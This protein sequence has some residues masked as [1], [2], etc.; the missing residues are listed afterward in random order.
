M[1]KNWLIKNNSKKLIL[2]FNG[3]GMD[4]SAVSHLENSGYDIIEFH[5]YRIIDFEEREYS[6]YKE[7]YL[8]AW[9]LG[10][11]AASCA[12]E[13]SSLP[14]TKSIAINGTQNP[15]HP[16]EGIHPAIFEGTI[17]G[18]NEKNK[19][20]FLRRTI[21][22]KNKFESYV[23]KFGERKLENQKEELISLYLQIKNGKTIDFKF[24]TALIGNKDTIF[25]SQNQLNQWEGKSKLI[26][27]KMPHYPFFQFNSWDEIIKL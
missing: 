22:S 19:T 7:V 23:S 27:F 5:D 18:W 17:N 21:G 1:N 3:W 14:I 16:K 4:H 12:L 8:V 24:D 15:V 13:K 9:S 20:R 2:F 6:T 10:V 26:H 25:T 11:W